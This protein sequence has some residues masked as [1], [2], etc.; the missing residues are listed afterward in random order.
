MPFAGVGGI[1]GGLVGVADGGNR[2][3]YGVRIIGPGSECGQDCRLEVVM[4]RSR[5]S[6]LAPV[7]FVGR[8]IAWRA[9]AAGSVPCGVLEDVPPDGSVQVGVRQFNDVLSPIVV[10]D[11]RSLSSV[12][13][14]R[15]SLALSVR[16]S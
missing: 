6:P 9:S 15:S 3:R 16:E 2:S 12:C 5:C 1:G 10:N 7:L 14:A 13:L 4:S 8:M 11:E